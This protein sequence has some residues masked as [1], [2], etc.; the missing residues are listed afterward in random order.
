MRFM[1]GDSELFLVDTNILVYSYD[2][3]E[4]AKRDK[5]EK[6]LSKCFSGD[7]FLAIS[8]QNLAEFVYVTTRKSKLSFAQAKINVDDISNSKNFKKINY[9]AETVLSAIEIANE[10]KTSFWDALLAATMRENG[11][12]NIYT[13]NVNDFKMPWINAVNP[14]K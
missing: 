11:I 9:D 3:D 5:A 1:T 13:E 14:L 6:L 8:N 4:P 10:F 2:K 12:F 7:A